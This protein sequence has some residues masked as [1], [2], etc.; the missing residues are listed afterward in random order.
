MLGDFH[1]KKRL[2]TYGL[3]DELPPQWEQDEARNY[4]NCKELV[5][6]KTNILTALVYAFIFIFT[7]FLFTRLFNFAV[8]LVL[9]FALLFF[10]LKYAVIGMIELYQHYA[11]EH[12]RRRCLFMPTCSEYALMAVRK[13]GVVAGLYKSY[14]RLFYRCKGN[15]YQIDYP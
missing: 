7:A 1:F 5:R 9:I 12:I 10:I 11:P 13:Y 3:T 4:V 6:P 15:V 8:S 14:F 2:K